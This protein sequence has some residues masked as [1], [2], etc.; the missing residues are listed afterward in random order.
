MSCF[1]QLTVFILATNEQE[2]L[3]QTVR[4]VVEAC[5]AKTLHEIV[6]VLP[7][8]QCPAAKICGE[9]GDNACGVPFHPYYQKKPDKIRFFSEIP[10]LTSSSHF[11]IMAG[12]MEM[13]PFSL[14]AMIKLAKEK[15]DAIVCGAK[16]VKGSQVFG[17]G[18]L[19]RLAN[20]AV[21]RCAALLLHS[22]GKELFSIF[23]IYP[24]AV[25]DRMRFN[26]AIPLLFEYTLLPV[27]QG[28][29]YIEIPTVYHKRTEGASNSN[30]WVYLLMGARFILTAGKLALRK[31]KQI[32]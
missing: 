3:R 27:S 31:P 12:D 25:F 16:W 29:E 13:D 19:H 6:A 10:P 18:F 32:R 7:S 26:P 21:N 5:G 17:Y 15:P 4:S 2:S 11:V 9:F 20:M 1:D 22:N 23:E 28:V 24:K 14:G 8:D 30:L